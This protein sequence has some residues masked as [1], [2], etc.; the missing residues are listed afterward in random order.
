[1]VATT[2]YLRAG[3]A[4]GRP[5]GVD[6]E[7]RTIKGYVVAEA[8]DF[9]TGRGKFDRESLAAIAKLINASADGM[10]VNYGH[11]PRCGLV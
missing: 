8:G 10:L 7:T 9:K 1:M 2:E 11:Q 4:S 6:E 3:S 5:I